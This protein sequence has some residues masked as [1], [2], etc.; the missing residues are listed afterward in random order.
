[1]KNTS[2][3]S[4]KTIFPKHNS[5]RAHTWWALPANCRIL[6]INNLTSE[7]KQ[8]VHKSTENIANGLSAF[9]TTMSVS[10]APLSLRPFLAKSHSNLCIPILSPYIITVYVK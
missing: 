9:T 8:P 10:K 6:Q 7:G 1:M 3:V 2:T 4:A 5:L